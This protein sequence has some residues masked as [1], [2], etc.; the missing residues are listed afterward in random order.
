MTPHATSQLMTATQIQG[1]AAKADEKTAKILTGLSV[2]VLLMML[3]R[4]GRDMFQR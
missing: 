4:E 2:V 3:V 1:M